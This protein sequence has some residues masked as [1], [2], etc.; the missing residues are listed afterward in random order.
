MN[1]L[2]EIQQK[3]K[4]PKG[5]TNKFGGYNYRSCEDILEAV[6][7]LL[8]GATLILSDAIE[9]IGGRVYVRATATLTDKDSAWMSTAY[10]REAEAKKGMDEAQITG[11]A[12]S[13]ARKY[14]L[15]GLL[16]IDDTRDSDSTNDHGKGEHL[17]QDKPVERPSVPRGE[18]PKADDLRQH[19]IGLLGYCRTIRDGICDGDIKTPEWIGL[20][21][22][23]MFG[24][25]TLD[26]VNE[27]RLLR[28]A[29]EQGEIDTETGNKVE[30]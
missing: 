15:N 12:S 8:G 29:I 6:K 21:A 28:D 10:A 19:K 5:Q 27:I 30:I 7:P 4:A 2:A 18:I 13:Y 17:R 9:A 23:A 25:K 16:C 14:A 11:S 20:A 24:K 3:L 22:E 26:S 1:K